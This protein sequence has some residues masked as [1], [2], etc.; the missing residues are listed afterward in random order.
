MSSK[1][2]CMN[3][4]KKALL[5]SVSLR[6]LA[7]TGA[8]LA[9]MTLLGACT[10]GADRINS[11]S[12]R[13]VTSVN[14]CN[15][16]A[17]TN[18]CNPAATNPCNPVAAAK[19]CNPCAAAN[20]CKPTAAANPC[21]PCATAK[22]WKPT[23][24]TNPC[25]PCA[26]NPCKPKAAANPCN[27]CAAANPCK[28]VAAYNPCAAQAVAKG[29]FYDGPHGH[30][31]TGTASISRGADGTYW[32]TFTEFASDRGPDINIILSPAPELTSNAAVEGAGYI[33]VAARKALTGDQ[34]YRLPK[35]FDPRLY[36]SVGIWCE[37]FAVLFGAARLRTL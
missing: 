18:P 35:D 24:A 31:A 9:S 29:A 36:R 16:A 23:A 3:S 4:E 11:A 14:P 32:L 13:P 6:T 19:P 25:N 27:P 1:Y 22:P 33:T 7:I 8:A 2:A 10:S 20:P 34:S 5:S 26:A 17:A 37:E 28:P 30:R 12:A 21:N 15:P